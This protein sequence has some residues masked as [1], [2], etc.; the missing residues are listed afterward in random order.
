[1]TYFLDTSMGSHAFKIGSEIYKETQW[2][3]REQSVGGNIEHI[4]SN[5]RA[6]QVIFGI[7]TALHVGSLR[8]ND[9]GNLLVENKLDQY[10]AFINDTWT[11]GR[12]TLNLG[13]RWDRYHGWMPEQRQI[14]YTIGPVS[15][16]EAVFTERHFFTWNAIGPRVGLTYDLAGDG[17]TVVK[18]ATGCSG[19][20]PGRA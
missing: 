18:A 3:G 13:A 15:V 4:Y 2:G 1:M 9:N 12:V 17:K 14:A 19:T 8:D 10:D 6:S 11:M 20:T 5:G 16:P 7:P